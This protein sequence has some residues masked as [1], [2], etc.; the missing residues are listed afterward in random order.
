MN[1]IT[2]TEVPDERW[3][4]IQEADKRR[5]WGTVAASRRRTSTTAS[6]DTNSMFMY[7]AR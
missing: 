6:D 7:S 3:N 5:G 1:A 2:L 4:H